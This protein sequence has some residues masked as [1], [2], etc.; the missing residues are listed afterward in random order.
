MKG[1]GI[2]LMVVGAA[3]GVWGFVFDI[4]VPTEGGLLVEV[5]NMSLVSQRELILAG[6]TATFSAGAA[7]AAVGYAYERIMEAI[8]KPLPKAR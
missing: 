8:G 1:L 4:T 3:L 2:I 7:F 6:A 5:T